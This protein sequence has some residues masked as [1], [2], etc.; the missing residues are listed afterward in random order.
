MGPG[1]HRPGAAVKIA[2]VNGLGTGHT[3]A[4]TPGD[5]GWTELATGDFN[6]DGHTDVLW[7]HDSD[8]ATA[9]WLMGADGTPTSTPSYLNTAGWSLAAHGDFGGNAATDLLWTNAGTGQSAIWLMADGNVAS[10]EFSLP[11]NGWTAIGQ[12][13]FNH[14][15]TTDVLWRED[16]TGNTAAWLMKDGGPSTTPTYFNTAGWNLIATADLDG[17]GTTDLL[18]QNSSTGQVAAWFMNTDGTVGNHPILQSPVTGGPGSI[19]WTEIGTGDFNGDGTTDVLWKAPD[20]TVGRLADGDQ[21]HHQHR[22]DL[23]ERGRLEPGGQRR[24]QP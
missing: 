24:L 7:R 17:N 8:G 14:D 15:G 18:W 21:R 19:G 5:G 11:T 16:A 12:G 3:D 23:P 1:R 20:G 9:A 6:N 2:T 4:A 22:P 10:H 13:D